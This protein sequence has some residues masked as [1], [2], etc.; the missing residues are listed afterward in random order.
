MSNPPF[1]PSLALAD[2]LQRSD[3]LSALLQRVRQSQQRLAVVL[4]LLP[5]PLRAGLS[6][7]PLDDSA[8]QLVVASQAA[9]AKLRQLLPAMQAALEQA[10]LGQPPIK[11]KLRGAR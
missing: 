1:K 10:G 6:A 3:P 11:L 8:W 4:P 2:A 7:G 5:E 9:A